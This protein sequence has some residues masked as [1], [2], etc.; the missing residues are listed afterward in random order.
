MA[1]RLG[2]SSINKSIRSR[3]IKIVQIGNSVNV[4]ALIDTKN[5]KN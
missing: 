3:I 1:K 4:A 5:Q 2:V